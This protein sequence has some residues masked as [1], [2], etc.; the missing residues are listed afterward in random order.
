MY[1]DEHEAWGHDP[2]PLLRRPAVR[3]AI[4]LVVI[5]TFVMLTLMST[6]SPRTTPIGTTTT[7]LDGVTV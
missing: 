3:G 7:T 5:V 6:C 2:L 1:E 4:T